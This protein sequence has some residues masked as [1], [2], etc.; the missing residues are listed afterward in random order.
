MLVTF[1]DVVRN[2]G[3]NELADKMLSYVPVITSKVKEVFHAEWRHIV[4]THGDAWFNNFL[5]K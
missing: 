4:L 2:D 5:F 3:D 1:A